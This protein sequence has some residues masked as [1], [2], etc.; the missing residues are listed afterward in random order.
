MASADVAEIAAWHG[1]IN[2][3]S[4]R[5]CRLEITREV[6]NNLS[7]QTRPVD[8]VDRADFVFFLKFEVV[9]HRF[10]HVLTVVKHAFNGNVMDVLVH[11]AE[12]LR[13][14]K[15]AH[16]ALRAGHEDANTLFATHGIFRCTAS[17]ATGRAKD[18]QRFAASR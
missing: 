13:L 1:E 6:I 16:A 4:V 7:Q 8:A 15:G 9:R 2:L 17:V 14:L 5:T 10:D 11:Q 18:I 12:H 3:F